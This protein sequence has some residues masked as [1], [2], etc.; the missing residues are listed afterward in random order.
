M[1]AGFGQRLA[2]LTDTV[3]KPLLPIGNLPLIGYAIALLKKHGITQI[4]VN[5]HHLAE[6]LERTLGDGSKFGVQLQ[7]SREEEILGTGGGLKRMHQW[8][9]E[10]FVVVNSDVLVEHDLTQAIAEHTQRHATATMVLR[11]TDAAQSGLAHIEMDAQRRIV[12]LFA[13]GNLSPEAQLP[14]QAL[15]FT[16]V[17]I[18]EPKFLEYIPSNVHTCVVRYGY[19]KALANQE[20]LYASVCDGFWRDAGTPQ[21]FLRSNHEALA[22]ALPLSYVDPLAGYALAPKKDLGEAVRMGNDVHLGTGVQ[23]NRPVALGDGCSFADRSV[24]GPWLV[25]GKGCTVGKEAQI[26]NSVLLAGASLPAGSVTQNAIVGSHA[27]LQVAPAASGEVSPEK[28]ADA[29]ALPAAVVAAST[30]GVTNEP[31]P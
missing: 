12:R 13:Q 3:P 31:S 2:P 16:G 1:A 15:M 5:T 14:V 9:D 30:P 25:A 24:V 8:L 4:T 28:K 23:I 7:Y 6:V 26:R 22:Q 27:R 29:D 17:H 10:T 19:A 21:D 11:K 18:L 20:P